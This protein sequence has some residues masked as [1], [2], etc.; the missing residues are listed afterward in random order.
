MS[1]VQRKE[2]GDRDWNKIFVQIWSMKG[3]GGAIGKARFD[4]FIIVVLMENLYRS[5]REPLRIKKEP[6]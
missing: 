6:P 2:R 1:T 3:L 5:T 4:L